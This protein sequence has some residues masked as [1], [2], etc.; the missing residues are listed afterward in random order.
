MAISFIG[1]VYAESTG[2][3]PPTHQAGDLFVCFAYRDGS[4]IAPSLPAGWSNSNSAGANTNSFRMGYKIAAS[5]SDTCTGWTNASGVILHVYR[6]AGALGGLN[7]TSA[8]SAT[9][10]YPAIT[11]GGFTNQTGSSWVAAF[12]G[13]RSTNTTTMTTPPTGMTNRG[14]LLGVNSDYASHDTDGGVSSWVQRTVATGGTASGYYTAVVEVMNAQAAVLTNPNVTQSTSTA[15]VPRVT[16]DWPNG[17]V[18]MVVVP[19]G[20]TPTAAQI[21]AGQRS[22]GTAAFKAENRAVTIGGQQTFTT[23]T[24]LTTGTEYDFWFVHN[25]SSGDSTPVKADFKPRQVVTMDSG[26][27]TPGSVATGSGF[28]NATAVTSDDGVYASANGSFNPYMYPYNYGFSLPSD[29]TITGMEVRLKVYNES[30]GG[31]LSKVWSAQVMSDVFN[32]SAAYTVNAPQITNATTTPAYYTLGSTSGYPTTSWGGWS[33]TAPTIS[34]INSTNFG[35]YVVWQSGDGF[36][37]YIDTAQIRFTYTRYLTTATLTGQT[38]DYVSGTSGTPRVTSDWSQGTLYMVVVPDGDTPSVAQIKAGQRSNG[39]SAIRAQSQAVTSTGVQTLTTLTGLEEY[40]NYDVWFVQS[41]D[42]GDSNAVKFDYKPATR[43]NT[44]WVYP[45]TITQPVGVI[46]N[47]TTSSVT[48]DRQWTNP[49]NAKAPDTSYALMSYVG[50]SSTS[51]PRPLVGHNFGLSIPSDASIIGIE[52]EVGVSDAT[53]GMSFY[54]TPAFVLDK[55]LVARTSNGWLVGNTLDEVKAVYKETSI[56][57]GE[58]PVP[59][60]WGSPTDMWSGIAPYQLTGTAP[61][62]Y[63]VH[64]TERVIAPSDLNSNDFG[65]A[66]K[67]GDGLTSVTGIYSIVDYM[68]IRVHYSLSGAPAPSNQQPVLFWAFP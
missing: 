10:T 40:T 6:G 46:H 44:G 61:N 28:A 63:Y 56:Q 41:N 19:N 38:I 33:A 51:L 14:S 42:A 60:S 4:A 31:S 27:K 53:T 2:V 30:T 35:C 18:Y 62:Q 34:T 23:V 68:K 8:S 20:D 66:L 36:I 59:I 7:F 64:G 50:S 67:V 11:A 37:G 65:L 21:K 22:N 26:W 13:H 9:L 45:G 48:W 52:V 32:G 16:T 15:G 5:S 29:A 58:T 1:S 55:N 49:N 54:A 43:L 24:G 3:T 57:T 12:A 39:T 25:N 47:S 17:I